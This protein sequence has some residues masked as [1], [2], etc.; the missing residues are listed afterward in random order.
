MKE[1]TIRNDYGILLI[2]DD[3]DWSRAYCQWIHTNLGCQTKHVRT[4]K[5]GLNEL[6]LFK[7][8]FCVLLDLG[9]NLETESGLDVIPLFTKEF[10]NIPL[11]VLSGNLDTTT[12]NLARNKVAMWCL[13]KPY[14]EYSYRQNTAMIIKAW[15][16]FSKYYFR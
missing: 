5:D 2:D 4:V 8:F 15:Q 12:I 13:D 6:R 7:I 1:N 11:I 10:P 14:S 16:E 9:L 3:R